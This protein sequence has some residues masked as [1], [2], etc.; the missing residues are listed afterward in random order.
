MSPEIPIS[1]ERRLDEERRAKV[2]A[3]ITNELQPGT[4]I[5][6]ENGLQQAAVADFEQRPYQLEAWANLWQARED[7]A[8]KGLINLATGLGKTSVAV[9]DYAQ[10]RRSFAS[11]EH[12][13]RALFVVHRDNILSQASD[14]FG[15]LLPT[16]DRSRYTSS[17]KSLPTSE[18]TFTTFQS[19]VRSIDRFPPD[20]FDYI[21][22]DEAH[23]I[24][25]D[26]YKKAV[27]HFHPQFQLGLTA[28]PHRMDTRDIRIHFGEALYTKTLPEAIAGKYLAEVTYNVMMDDATK[29]AIETGFNARTTR[30]LRAAFESEL[31]NGE[32]VKKIRDKQKEIKKEEGVDTVKTIIFCEDIQHADKIAELI[33]GESYH[34]DLP[35]KAQIKAFQNFVHGN[36]ETITVRDMFNEGVDIPDARL[37]VFLRSTQSKPI[38]EQ[39][40]GRGLRRTQEKNKVVVMDFVANIDRLLM[41]EELWTRIFR[42]SSNN[43]LD[44]VD[45]GVSF[46]MG[47]ESNLFVFDKKIIE[48][49]DAY[50]RLAENEH[51]RNWFK[52]S[53]DEIIEI[54]LSLSPSKPL[55]TTTIQELSTKN[56]FPS[57]THLYK[58]FGTISDFQ[59]ACGFDVVNWRA[60]T[61]EDIVALAKELSPDRPIGINEIKIMANGNQF[62]SE[63]VIVNRFGNI[64]N[65]QLACG[66][67][68][69]SWRS[70]SNEDLV[71]IALH[72]S[73]DKPLLSPTIDDLSRD[74]FPSKGTIKNR[75]G[76]MKDFHN[77]CG[78]M[79]VDWN[80]YS[81]DDLVD[82]ALN[83]NPNEPLRT[84][85]FVIL[86]SHEF[87]AVSFIVNRFGNLSNFQK[88]CGFTTLRDWRFLT[89][90]EIV[91]LAK[92][93]SPSEPLTRNSR[94]NLEKNSFP[95]INILKEKFGSMKNFYEECGFVDFQS[96]QSNFAD[97]T[98]DELVLLAN[99]ISPDTPLT[100]SDIGSMDRK[101][102]PGPDFI[103]ARFG[104]MTT[105]QRARGF[106]SQPI[107]KWRDF[108]NQ[109]L[110]E[111]ALQLSPDKPLSSSQ[112][113]QLEKG[114][115]PDL[116]TLMRRFGGMNEFQEACGFKAIRKRKEN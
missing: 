32:I 108:S 87:P 50:K 41:L 85:D 33:G 55:R 57:L 31:R 69:V 93:L 109:D 67:N 15:T 6:H 99:L 8:Q 14:R 72:L 116:S 71:Q 92:E 103:K 37:I 60:Y 20:Y 42:E 46:K 97:Y 73:P 35:K 53:E 18:I 43:N 115:F 114:V 65:F 79:E 47:D 34:S 96:T 44:E 64:I 29:E 89:N 10:F 49:M 107:P 17:Q 25:A 36:F 104:S 48:L 2:S 111:L 30:E 23:H 19:L 13:P 66:F 52:V 95:G 28:T 106:N 62:P 11:T 105:F 27:D 22:Y 38:F 83:I 68:I 56:L 98:N 9:F 7:G 74:E 12:Q 91:A 63:Q 90:T 84:D 45:D 4:R 51:R 113:N 88:A 70:F 112:I 94:K 16:V 81:N 58:R 3:F 26:T 110:I 76:S 77:A 75:F 78:F 1:P 101:E 80:E 100:Y 39:Q 61:A 102:F 21:M 86:E 59:Q 54:A 5:L 24:E 82:L 40:L